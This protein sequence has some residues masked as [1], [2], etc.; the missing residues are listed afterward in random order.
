MPKKGVLKECPKTT[1]TVVGIPQG[2]ETNQVIL[3]RP[4]C[5][6]WDCEFCK[7]RLKAMWG[8]RIYYGV[9]VGRQFWGWE[10][11]FVTL[12]SHEKLKTFQATAA[13]WPK[14]WS[15]LAPRLRRKYG[16]FEYA[17]V[18]EMHKDGRLHFHFI[19][20]IEPQKTWLKKN[21]RTSGGGYQVD[22][23]K[24]VDGSL[25][26]WYVTKYLGKSMG[27]AADE[28]SKLKMRRVSV[29]RGWP[30]LPQNPEFVSDVTWEMASMHGDGSH[31]IKHY[32]ALG[33]NVKLIG[34][35]GDILHGDEPINPPKLDMTQK[36]LYAD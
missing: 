24:V 12:T 25:A 34:A 30:E 33:K 1:M 7:H 35:W 31:V 22:I 3:Y 17:R 29:S 32:E 16:S 4:S 8:Q 20:S 6:M 19:M 15:K 5:Q 2:V 10:T 28:F 36:V 11:S 9:N 18:P 14:V 26:S 21:A 23:Q 27:Q 13:V